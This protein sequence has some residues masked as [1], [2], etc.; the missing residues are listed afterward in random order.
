MSDKN[1]SEKHLQRQHEE[2]RGD[3]VMLKKRPRKVE[4]LGPPEALDEAFRKGLIAWLQGPEMGTECTQGDPWIKTMLQKRL[5]IKKCMD[6]KPVRM[7]RGTPATGPMS[8][9]G[10]ENSA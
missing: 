7:R 1:D 4:S 5:E 6:H 10:K 3:V 2:L 8:L 9:V